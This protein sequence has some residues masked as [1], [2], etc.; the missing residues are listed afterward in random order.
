MF[1]KYL[2]KL[3]GEQDEFSGQVESQD[4]FNAAVIALEKRIGQYEK[5]SVKA[6]H[7]DWQKE[8][9]GQK[10][11][12]PQRKILMDCAQARLERLRDAR[13][14]YLATHELSPPGS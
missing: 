13:A 7:L 8:Q 12:A 9:I 3:F 14:N 11:K 5:P 1:W 4:S 10:S 6:L 2:E